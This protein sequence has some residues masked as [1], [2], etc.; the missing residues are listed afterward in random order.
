MTQPQLQPPVDP[1][2]QTIAFDANL[3][4][5]GAPAP[6]RFV[7]H[8]IM[9]T[10]AAQTIAFYTGLFGWTTAEWDMG[11]AGMYTML[12]NGAEAI[13]GVG[14]IDAGQAAPSHWQCYVTVRSVDAAVESAVALGGSA[15]YPATDIPE[16]GRFAVIVD[17]SGARISPFKSLPGKESPESESRPVGS[18]IWYELLTKDP[19]SASRF[20]EEIF[21]WTHRAED[22][23]PFGTYYLFAREGK[24][25]AGMMKMPEDA[26]G[27]SQWVPYVHVADVDASAARVQELGGTLYV[28]PAD[29]PN[30]GRFSVCADPLGATFSIYKPLMR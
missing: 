4:I 2:A 19:E 25:L 22:M 10:D 13:G 11:P 9:T 3:S 15:P 5:P 27:P 26:A 18:F 6:G 17:Q 1:T 29:I 24:D 20:Y 7:W 8:D 21:G 16:V 30:V 12:H 28:A 14:P 23:G